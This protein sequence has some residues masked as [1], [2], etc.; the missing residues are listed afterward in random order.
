[1]QQYMNATGATKEQAVEW[2]RQSV[3]D[4][5]MDR[6]IRTNREINPYAA[7]QLKA[8]LRSIILIQRFIL[9]TQKALQNVKKSLCLPKRAKRQ[10][11]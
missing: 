6:V 4:S 5:N 2:L 1:M 11:A 8:A 9:S 7:M 3:V 10:A